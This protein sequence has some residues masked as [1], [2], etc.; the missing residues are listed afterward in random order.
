MKIGKEDFELWRANPV[1]EA[2]NRA[3]ELIGTR[4]KNKW[5]E[6][7]WDGGDTDPIKLAELRA[8]YEAAWDLSELT[9]E[10]LERVLNDEE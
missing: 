7:S 10:E 4:N 1:T 5:I 9:F 3:L 2:V 6:L 8:R